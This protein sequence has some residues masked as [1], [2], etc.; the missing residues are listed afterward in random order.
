[1]GNGSKLEQNVQKI[2]TALGKLG[3]QPAK[4]VGQDNNV[5]HYRTIGVSDT[6]P[7]VL[8]F[9]VWD[10]DEWLEEYGPA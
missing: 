7:Y 8:E 9:S 1:M 3:F 10:I 4:F 2:S 6:L 5:M